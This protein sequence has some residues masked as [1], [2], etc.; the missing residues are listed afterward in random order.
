MLDR[1]VGEVGC[2]LSDANWA[3]M[4][5]SV[6]QRRVRSGFRVKDEGRQGD[7]KGSHRHG[8]WIYNREAD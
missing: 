4:N 5:V 2:L 3:A 7:E 8:E 1:E 6:A